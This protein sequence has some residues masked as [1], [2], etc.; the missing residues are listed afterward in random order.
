[1]AKPHAARP[2][3]PKV[4][5]NS[6]GVVLRPLAL[7]FGGYGPG[8]RTARV[9]NGDS[10]VTYLN[11]HLA[12]SVMALKLMD[13]LSKSQGTSPLGDTIAEF[14]TETARDKQLVQRIVDA[15]GG[16]GGVAKK[17][18]AWFGELLSRLKLGQFSSV[19]GDLELFEALELLSVGFYG[20]RSLWQ[21][22]ERL[23][24]ERVLRLGIDF[25]EIISRVDSQ[26]E[27]I[28]AIRLDM[29]T[30]AFSRSRLP[31]ESSLEFADI[32]E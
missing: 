1:M 5:A 6:G 23:K 31:H 15:F 8:V 17:S 24:D 3:L 9:L 18:L 19:S 28:N 32:D 20:R 4:A 2:Q 25:A 16:G 29:A 21:M 26:L 30:G 11:D 27:R 10:L 12:A 14:A 13:R 22:L 7:N